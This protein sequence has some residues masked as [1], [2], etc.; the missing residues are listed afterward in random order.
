MH[1]EKQA[2]GTQ[3]RST[4]ALLGSRL[5]NEMIFHYKFSV[6]TLPFGIYLEN[7]VNKV[8]LSGSKA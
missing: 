6:T 4:P 8:D 3:H 2:E 5:I 7:R 1:V